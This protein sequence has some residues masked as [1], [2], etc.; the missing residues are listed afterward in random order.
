MK[1]FQC[2]KEIVNELHMVVTAPD[3]DCFCNQKC[4]DQFKKDREYFLN[5][6]IHDDALYNDWLENGPRLRREELGL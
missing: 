1:C 6:T 5:I 2:H 4:Y 3:G